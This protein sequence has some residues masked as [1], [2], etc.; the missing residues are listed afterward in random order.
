MERPPAAFGVR[1]ADACSGFDTELGVGKRDAR[2]PPGQ[3]PHAAEMP[4][5]A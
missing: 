2:S 4:L 1:A 3:P 5:I